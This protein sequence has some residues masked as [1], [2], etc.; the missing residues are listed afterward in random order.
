[1]GWG[2]NLITSVK[3]LVMGLFELLITSVKS[4]VMGLFKLLITSVKSF[5]MGLFKLLITSVKSLGPL[6]PWI[7]I[8]PGTPRV[9][10]KHFPLKLLWLLGHPELYGV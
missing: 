9:Q 6:Q 4:F 7:G 2:L 1:M 10:A 8:D 3:S 5:V